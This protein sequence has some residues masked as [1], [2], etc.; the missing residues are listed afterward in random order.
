MSTVSWLGMTHLVPMLSKT[1][2]VGEGPGATRS[3]S[4]CFFYLIS[5]LLTDV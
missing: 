1:H 5:N 3:V 4:M 2:V